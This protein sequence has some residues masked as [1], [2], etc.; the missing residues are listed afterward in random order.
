MIN[1]KKTN[2]A[3]EQWRKLRYEVKVYRIVRKDPRTP[4]SG[5]IL[6]T[7]AVLYAILPISFI[8]M[9]VPIFGILDEIIIISG[10]IYLAHRLIPKQV[11]LDARAEAGKAQKIPMRPAKPLDL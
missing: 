8:P 5:K 3:K 9:I 10:C 11:I 6:L 2:W 4:L 7:T 1:D